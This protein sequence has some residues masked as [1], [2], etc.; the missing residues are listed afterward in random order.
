VGAIDG[1]D[2]RVCR[3]FQAGDADAFEREVRALVTELEDGARVT[4]G[5]IARAEAERL[6]HPDVVTAD[7]IAELERATGSPARAD[8]PRERVL[9]G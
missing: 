6:F 3:V 5:P 4:L 2:P 9:A 7:L 1:L 8:D